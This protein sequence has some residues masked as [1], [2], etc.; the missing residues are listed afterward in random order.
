MKVLLL[1]VNHISQKDFSVIPPTL[2]ELHL[3]S[4]I[5]HCTEL[6]GIRF[7]KVS[8]IDWRNLPPTLTTLHLYSRQLSA[9]GDI[10]HCTELKVLDIRLNN[11]S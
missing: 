2:T 7:N 5:S 8:E 1:I 10:S 4:D 6:L 3:Y 11:I 9:A